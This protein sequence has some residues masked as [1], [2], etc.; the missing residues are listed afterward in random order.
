MSKVNFK[1]T[2]EKEER[3]KEKRRQ[4]KY[5]TLRRLVAELKD[6]MKRGEEDEEKFTRKLLSIVSYELNIRLDQ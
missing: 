4:F 6:T 2:I 1:N 3:Q 5:K